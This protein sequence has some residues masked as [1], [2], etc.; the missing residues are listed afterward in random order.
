M[1]TGNTYDEKQVLDSLS[2]GNELAFTQVFDRYRPRVYSVA[3]NLLKSS[4][5]AE[6]VVQDVF[7]KVWQKRENLPG[8]KR[9][10][11][12]LFMMARNNIYD[13]FKKLA[14]ET[15]ACKFFMGKADFIENTDYQMIEG[16]YT[17]ILKQ[18]VN[19]L[20]P[21]QKEVY[22]LA[23]EQHLSHEEIAKELNISRLTVK[24]HMAQALKL[25]RIRLEKNIDLYT[26]LPV[27]IS[28]LKS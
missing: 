10:D 25:I 14:H 13:H 28:I 9:F 11:A 4:T 23:K 7:L 3:L 15:E 8:I 19:K 22:L 2:K 5:L 27:I 21:Q 17:E 18:A 12:Y 26:F 16:E 24:T 20:T 1:A 6:E